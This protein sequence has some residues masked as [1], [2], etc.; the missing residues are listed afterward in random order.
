MEGNASG[1]QVYPVGRITGEERTELLRAWGPGFEQEG[2]ER[3]GG[4][5]IP[6]V[7]GNN[8]SCKGTNLTVVEGMH[9]FIMYIL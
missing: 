4:G 5:G 9:Q 1:Y 6:S 2:A 3:P 8:I 7:R